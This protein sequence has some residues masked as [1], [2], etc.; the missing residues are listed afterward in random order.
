MAV[1]TEIEKKYNFE[2]KRRKFRFFFLCRKVPVIDFHKTFLYN[3]AIV[4]YGN[5]A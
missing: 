4:H 5:A 1:K 3:M 2:G